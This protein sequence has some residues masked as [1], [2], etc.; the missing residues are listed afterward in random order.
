MLALD[1][2]AVVENGTGVVESFLVRV[3]IL[4]EVAVWDFWEDL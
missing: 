4:D 1:D 2:V 3:E